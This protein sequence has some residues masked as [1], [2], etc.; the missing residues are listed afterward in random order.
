MNDKHLTQIRKKKEKELK[1]NDLQDQIEG[2]FP[3]NSRKGEKRERIED[4]GKEVGRVRVWAQRWQKEVNGI[5][6]IA[7]SSK[8]RR[9]VD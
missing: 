6:I 1:K 8:R 4:G 2:L 7:P 9:F 5:R 3:V